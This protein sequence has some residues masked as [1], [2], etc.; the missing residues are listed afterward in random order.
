MAPGSKISH[1]EI[2]RKVGATALGT[3]YLAED[4]W[5]KRKVTLKMLVDDEHIDREIR[6]WMIAGA[7]KASR[8]QHPNLLAVYEIGN[9]EN[10][11]YIVMEYTE[12]MTLKQMMLTGRLS[13]D[14]AIEIT[15]Q[16]CAGIKELHENR[17]TAQ[18]LIP[19]QIVV[20]HEKQVKLI[21]FSMI[22]SSFDSAAELEAMP[23]DIVSF[24][25]PE[26]LNF[27]KI[28]ELSNIFSLGVLLYTMTAHRQPF[29]GNKAA[30]VAEA[31]KSL[32]P[33]APTTFNPDIPERLNRIIMK[34][35]DKNP[36]HRYQSID[37]IITEL[38]YFKIAPDYDTYDR[39]K[40]KDSWNWVVLVA[41]I[42]LVLVS[43]WDYI[44]AIFKGE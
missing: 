33:Q 18:L 34:M 15:R 36:V 27:R 31:I 25:S 40:P 10:H 16:L 44:V 29:I 30:G 12:G 26:Q 42:I 20:T 3:V 32:T 1:Y 17:M 8:I 13:I 5:K 37:E 39:K 19:E 9:I 43:L 7:E 11:D 4:S 6:D 21:N 35:L 28:D 24:M 41:F 22:D 38:G 23:E 14:G 2:I